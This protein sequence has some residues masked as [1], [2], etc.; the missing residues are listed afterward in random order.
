M[1]MD[2]LDY[3]FDYAPAVI[4]ILN[5]HLKLLKVN[6]ALAELCRISGE[7]YVGRSLSEV[8]PGFGANVQSLLEEVLF[9]DR[10]IQRDI[11]SESDFDGSTRHW[12]ILVFPC[13]E[14]EV[15][16]LATEMTDQKRIE[17]TLQGLNQRLESTLAEKEQSGVMN[18]MA[19]LLQAA[20]V[21]P[22]IYNIAGR[23]A[24]RLFPGSSGT[25]CI[26]NSPKNTVEVVSSWGGGVDSEAIFLPDDCWALR[27]GRAHL[28]NDPQSGLL[29]AHASRDVE[30][31]K[32]CVPMMAQYETMGILHLS[33]R[34]NS[35]GVPFTN[36]EI[37]LAE[38]VTQQIALP[39][40]NVKMREFLREQAL[41]DSLTGLYNRRYFEEVLEREI[42]RASRKQTPVGLIM[43]D[44]DHFKEL[45]DTR[46]HLAGD[47][48][49]RAVAAFLRSRLRSA[50]VI[51]RY[52][53][54]E[55]AIVMPE[56]S[57]EDTIK[58]AEELRKGTKS[59]NLTI[60]VG[61]A[62]FP[63]HGSTVEALI[64]EADTALYAA[65]TQGRDQVNS[66]RLSGLNSEESA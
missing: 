19:H 47:E 51:C 9:I 55:F 16:F 64:M 62:A 21:I 8:A 49:L 5:R 31:A 59:L 58:K 14:F 28:V 36:W 7:D 61:A 37:S 29:C 20:R 44:V 30:S 54:D 40:A 13:G 23:Y 48:Y 35:H 33:K 38:A 42:R 50:D 52:G 57:L 41:R 12:H 66:R 60:S 63:D 22:E 24:P 34:R 56:A 17:E 25:L 26:M 53:G 10:P 27:E 32:L 18:E 46:G 45:N 15:G 65:K 1:A 43:F 2:R 3:F 39:L 4:A 11:A 6:R